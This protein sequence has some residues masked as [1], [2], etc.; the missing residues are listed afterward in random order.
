MVGETLKW[1]SSKSESRI[2]NKVNFNSI[3]NVKSS[4][5]VK[6]GW[7]KETGFLNN[8]LQRIH[9]NDYYQYFSY[10]IKTKIPFDTW[11]KNVDELNHTSGFKKFGYENDKLFV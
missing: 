11:D 2:L 6:K 9:D 5:I 8:D 7:Q 3:Y 10:S 4:S 1:K